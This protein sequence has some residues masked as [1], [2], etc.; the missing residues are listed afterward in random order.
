[1]SIAPASSTACSRAKRKRF[2]AE[3]GYSDLRVEAAVD[4]LCA[5]LAQGGAFPHEIGLL[6]H[7]STMW[8]PLSPTKGATAPLR[9][10]KCYTDAE[11][12]QKAFCRFRA[13]Q[14]L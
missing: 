3:Q 4:L 2:L 14:R 13:H 8:L 5:R 6:G 11:A 9:C 7:P 10:W 1:M 12:A